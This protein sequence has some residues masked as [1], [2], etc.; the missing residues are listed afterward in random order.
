M[1]ADSVYKNRTTVHLVKNRRKLKRGRKG[2]FLILATASLVA[3]HL[4]SASTYIWDPSGTGGSDGS[5]NWDLSSS[6]WFSGALPDAVWPPSATTTVAQLGSGT[7]GTFT[8]TLN[9][10]GIVTNGIIFNSGSTYTLA[11]NGTDSLTLGGTTPTITVNAASANIS[12]VLT[13]TAGMTMAGTGT[14]TLSGSNS[15]TGNTVVPSGT[16]QVNSGGTLGATSTTLY[17]GNTGGTATAV[18]NLAVNSNVTVANFNVNT[19]NSVDT[20]V[21]ASGSKV[22]DNGVFAIQL[23]SSVT[24]ATNVNLNTYTGTN[25]PGSGGELDVNGAMTVGY[26]INGA[27]GANTTATV[28]LSG[29]STFKLNDPSSANLNIGA[30]TL[31]QGMLTLANNSNL[32]NFGTAYIGVSTAPGN[33]GN[34][35]AVNT[36]NGGLMNLGAGTNTIQ[37]TALNIG[38]GKANG[39]IQFGSAAGSV[40]I[41]GYNGSGTTAITVGNMNVSGSNSVTNR[42]NGLLLAGHTAT[43]QAGTVLIGNVAD[44]ASAPAANATITFDTGTFNASSITIGQVTAG[45]NGLNASFVLGTSNTSTGILTDSGNFVLGNNTGGTSSSPSFIINGGTANL[46]NGITITSNHTTSATLTL[47]GGVLNVNG[48]GIGSSTATNTTLTVNMPTGGQT[49]A[50]ENLGGSGIYSQAGTGSTA[51]AGGLV[52]SD[53]GTLILAG[54]NNSYTGATTV[55]SGTLQIGSGTLGG[56]LPAASAVTN[57]GAITFAGS[58]PIAISNNISGSGSVTHNSSAMTTLS[59]TNTYGGGTTINSGTLAVN[60]SLLS[61]GTVNV[62]GG[63]LAGTGN[64]GIINMTSGAIHP[65]SSGADFNIGTLSTT[66]FSGS[67]GDMRFDLGGSTPDLISDSGSAVFNGG[68][69]SVQLDSAPAP[70]VTSYTV[71]TAA[72]GISGT[73][74]TLPPTTIGRTT[75]TLSSTSTALIINLTGTPANLIWGKLNGST[76]DGTTWDATQPGQGFNTDQNWNNSGTADQ[77]YND[78]L[79]TFNDNNNGNTAV[80]VS[81]TVTPGSVTFA[82]NTSN[83][84]FSGSGS[85]GG[86]TGITMNGT[87]MVTLQNS[88]TYT[89]DTNINSGTFVL[90]TGG[91]VADT[92][93]NV[94]GGI[95]SIAGGTLSSTNLTVTSGAVNVTAGNLNSSNV[96]VSGGSLN[97]STGMLS[98]PIVTV[99]SGGTFYLGSGSTVLPTVN[100]TLNGVGNLTGSASVGILNG[101]GTF[102]TNGNVLS[103]PSGGTFSGVIADGSASGGLNV[104]T[105]TLILTGSNTYSGSTTIASGATLQLGANATTGSINSASS[106]A[107]AGTLA[108]NNS[109][110]VSFSNTLTGAG[111]V[112][113]GG[114]GTV[115]LSSDISGYT[116]SFN[117]TAGSFAFNYTSPVTI[118]NNVA[119]NGG[120]LLNLGKLTLTGTETIGGGSMTFNVSAVAGTLP[121]GTALPNGTAADV[122]TTG[123]VNAVNS[124]RLIKSGP[125]VLALSG[126]TDDSAL[127]ATVNGGVLMLNKS[128]AGGAHAIGGFGL[129]I[130]NTGEAI[131]TGTGGNQI[132]DGNGG[133]T[134]TINDGGTF[135]LNGESETINTL[136]LGSSFTTSNALLSDNVPN[137]H[138]TL[139]ANFATSTGL[140]IKGN[141]NLFAASGATLQLTVDGTNAA[142]AQTGTITTTG[143]GTV[144]LDGTSDNA[145]LGLIVSNGTVILAKINSNTG[146]HAVSSVFGVA[147]GAMLQL[148]STGTGS[149]QIY[150]GF[151]TTNGP[152]DWGVLNMNG[153]FDMNGMSEGF[154]KLTGTGNVI[155]SQTSNSVLTLGTI[156]LQ[157]A[158]NNP[159]TPNFAGNITGNITLK[160]NEPTPSSSNPLILTGTGNSYTGGTTI[161]SGFIEVGGTAGG[162][163]TGGAMGLG[164]GPV[165][166][167]NNMALILNRSDTNLVIP[168]NISGLGNLY[169]IGSGT[170]TLGGANTYTGQTNILSGELK[171]TGANGLNGTQ[172][173]VSG[174]TSVVATHQTGPSALVLASLGNGGLIDLNNNGLVVS[175]ANANFSDIYNQLTTG[176]H[177]GSWTGTSGIISTDAA[178]D[179]THLTTLGII[180]NDTGANSGSPTGTAAYTTFEGNPTSDGDVLVKYTYYGD[181]NLD[182]HVD[183]SDYSLIDTGYQGHLTG[184]FNGD[185]NYDGVVDGSDYSLIDNDFNQQSVA[186]FASEVASPMAELA[187]TAAVPEPASLGLIAMGAIGLLSR[188]RRK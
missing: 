53:T 112:T 138:S 175:A 91:S 2:S 98:S 177:T 24:A 34:G 89:G 113:Q 187:G 60:G 158:A 85:I 154:D 37:A 136:Q 173:N 20:L 95:L 67:G 185:F 33:Q 182:G 108:F 19:R 13:G 23:A 71:F 178:T 18:S 83:Y 54:T 115:N 101:S 168:G 30:S 27:T 99:A 169:V 45:G 59:G 152:V 73:L 94:S 72:G 176:Y 149:D 130:N 6:N 78:D 81:G 162:G 141:S 10:V 186:G 133:A 164:T 100:L 121:S 105:G 77:F 84:V 44:G 172:L 179:P 146:A 129:I 56:S 183:G 120:T 75:F 150:D 155:N 170:V 16:L 82:N 79:V 109:G 132:Y 127:G 41:A 57:N 118:S 46:N 126:S 106:V 43:V 174:G 21:I 22:V 181:A 117:L 163:G 165:S 86:I 65:G 167:A 68:T 171:L 11:Q 139:T 7:A 90:G 9:D 29:L 151:S 111:V 166:I 1:Q 102:N 50:I 49:A 137:S 31:C 15:Y 61:T 131:I 160:L 97:V 52:M 26:Q 153:T 38:G 125:G 147:P 70:G 161:T 25:V 76:G 110:T 134:V 128:T 124:G 8:V 64:A 119:G 159:A 114:S 66:G 156:S 104:P 188:R 14:L 116:G 5:G 12:A 144:I 28:D 39:V 55:N 36:Q 92:N 40:S 145:N 107:V 48:K 62:S 180:I 142:G 122:E 63:T 143:P 47:A 123:S 58:Q 157:N 184:W 80:T 51:N 17:L 42:T 32:L 96:L 4:V 93:F 69:I 140:L 88:N 74:P 87:G 103:V 3:P 35:N 148:G 135:E